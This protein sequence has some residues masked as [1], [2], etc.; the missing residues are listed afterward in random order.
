MSPEQVQTLIAQGIA[1][2]DVSVEGADGRHFSATVVSEQ[3]AG[4]TPVKRQQLVY[5]TIGELVTR[6]A[7]H[8]ISL[9][10]YTPA[11]WDKKRHSGF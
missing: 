11:E 10:T 3:F 5:A 2:A 8:A 7:I 9:R 6:D 4:L 1:G